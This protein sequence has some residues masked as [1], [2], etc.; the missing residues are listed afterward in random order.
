MSSQT[1]SAL[2]ELEASLTRAV[3][4][5][6]APPASGEVKQVLPLTAYLDEEASSARWRVLSELREKARPLYN[7]FGNER[8]LAET[9]VDV[10]VQVDGEVGWDHLVAELERFVDESSEWLISVP[11]ANA[12]SAGYVE[13]GDRV[14]LAEVQQ[15][16]EWERDREP[17]AGG[18][19]CRRSPPH[20][21]QTDA[22]R[23]PARRRGADPG[24]CRAAHR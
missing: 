22:T 15:A 10:V 3:A 17:P 9:I 23:G 2:E 8:F 24:R 12:T 18:R 5:R 4:E 11:L 1:H 20:C 16:E 7:R 6:D 19:S 13:I 14:A 21:P